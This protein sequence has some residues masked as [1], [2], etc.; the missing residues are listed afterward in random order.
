MLG[1]VLIAVVTGFTQLVLTWYG[2][3]VSVRENRMRNAFIIGFVG[4]IGIAFT[5]W[6]AIRS[7]NYQRKLEFDI[8]S[9]ERGQQTANEG[10]QK[11]ENAPP[12]TV[13][14]DTR[15]K[16]AHIDFDSPP[17]LVNGYPMFPFHVGQEPALNMGFRNG[18]D[19]VPALKT[20]K[21]ALVVVV[22]VA[23]MQ[24]SFDRYLVNIKQ[25]SFSHL[26]TI[27]PRADGGY[28][29]HWADPLTAD[30]VLQLNKGQKAVCGLALITWQDETGKYE[31]DFGE[32]LLKESTGNFNWHKLAIDQ[33]ETKL[34]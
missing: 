24:K 17:N 22:P 20:T 7:G 32:C 26:D 34:E 11:I 3:H 31:T 6:G 30:D 23:D 2:I 8:A 18:S 21:H 1:D 14:V 25:T 4:A 16:H 9:L 13:T 15:P 29:S 33:R 27:N 10:I 12:P 28:H 19:E 5:V